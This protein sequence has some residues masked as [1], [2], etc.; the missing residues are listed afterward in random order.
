MAAK[1]SPTNESFSWKVLHLLNGTHNYIYNYTNTVHYDLAVLMGTCEIKME[2]IFKDGCQNN[3]KIIDK[4]IGDKH[5]NK[6]FLVMIQ[7][8]KKI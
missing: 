8:E 2:A 4:H 3:M 5:F 6:K 1:M 7:I